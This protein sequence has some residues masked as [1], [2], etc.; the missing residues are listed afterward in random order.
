MAG[1]MSKVSRTK[2]KPLLLPR[3]KVLTRVKVIV[4]SAWHLWNAFKPISLEW[5]LRRLNGYLLKVVRAVVWS[6]PCPQLPSAAVC[7]WDLVRSVSGWC[8]FHWDGWAIL[9]ACFPFSLTHAPSFPPTMHLGLIPPEVT[10][11]TVTL[12][13]LPMGL[14]AEIKLTFLWIMQVRDSAEQ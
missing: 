10:A 14:S 7:R 4:A 3:P 2:L 8:L 12:G 6:T 9:G 5:Q 11:D 1:G 13:F